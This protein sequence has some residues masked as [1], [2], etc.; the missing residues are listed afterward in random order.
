MEL[1]FDY[2]EGIP[3]LAPLGGSEG[4]GGVK[5]PIRVR[6]RVKGQDQG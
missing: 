2:G 3:H 6:V 1:G 4:L 5:P